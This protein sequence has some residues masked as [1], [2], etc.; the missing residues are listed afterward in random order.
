MIS[1]FFAYPY[2]SQVSMVNLN[3]FLYMENYKDTQLTFNR[4]SESLQIQL[5]YQRASGI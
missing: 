2:L 3:V 5:L 1:E 4:F